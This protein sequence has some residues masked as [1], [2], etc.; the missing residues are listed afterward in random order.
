MG[1]VACIKVSQTSAD[2]KTVFRAVKKAMELIRWESNVK[3]GSII[4]KIN[5]V[6]DHLYPSCTTSPMVIE[7]IL[8]VILAEKKIKPDAITIVDT[9]TAAMMSADKSFRIQGIEALAQKYGVHLVNLTNTKFR[10][11][12]FKGMVLTTLKISRILLEADNFITIPVLKTHSYSGMTG[13]LKNQ[14]GCIHDLRLNYHMVLHQ[15]IVDVN[16]FFKNK[17]S[18]GLM[19]ALF[20]MDGKG[21]KAGRPRK[22][23]YIFASP[24]LVALDSAACKVMGLPI[25]DIKYI[26]LAEKAGLGS[27]KFSILGDSLPSYHFQPATSSNIVMGAEMWF[28]HRGP[29]MEWLMFNPKSPVFLL[30]RWSAKIYYDIWYLFIGQKL[31]AKMMRTNYG[32]MWSSRYL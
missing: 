11:I 27:T 10:E 28:R 30:L 17:I 29:Q 18:F 1:K 9:D 25:K 13:G 21:P 3:K 19:D 12:G 2:P 20:G 22:V 16:C 32:R 24:D 6:W 15:A 14:W 8:K 26:G 4:L 31:A 23:G 7:G 5:A